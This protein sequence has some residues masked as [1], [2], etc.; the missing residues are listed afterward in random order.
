[1]TRD[2]GL[3]LTA[4]SGTR[5]NFRCLLLV[6]AVYE[7]VAKHVTPEPRRMGLIVV[8]LSTCSRL[9]LAH[10]VCFSIPF[11]DPLNIAR[12]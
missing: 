8:K 11:I 12:S 10:T 5:N 6:H 4:A 2:H 7:V 9:C 1:M 3:D